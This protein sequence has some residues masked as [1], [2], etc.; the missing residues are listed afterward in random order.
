MIMSET[1]KS[2]GPDFVFANTMENHAP[3]FY[4]GKFEKNTF[5]VQG[6]VSDESKEMLETYATGIA[7]ADGMLQ[8][9]AEHYTQVDEPT[10]VVFF[11]GDHMPLLGNNYKV[12]KESNY[13]SENDPD[14]VRKKMYSTPVVVWNNYLPEQKDQFSIS[15]SFLSSYVLKL[16]GL[17]GTYFTDFLDKLSQKQPVIPPNYKSLTD[18]GKQIGQ[19][20]QLQYDILFGD[21]YGYRPFESRIVDSNFVLGL[22]AMAAVSVKTG[23]AGGKTDLI[24]SGRNFVPGAILYLDNKRLATAWNRDGSLTAIVPEEILN[25]TGRHQADVRVLDSKDMIIA[26]TNALDVTLL[27]EKH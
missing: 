10:V 19:Y 23:S 16:T 17:K 8:M 27:L 7:D 22:G 20:K 11:F 6:P 4:N 18:N 12:Y 5:K 24:V 14:F 26:K 25:K 21:R 1:D 9:L 3:F 15:P 2:P 13:L